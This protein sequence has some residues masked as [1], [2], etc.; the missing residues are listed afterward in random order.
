M[1]GMVIQI[2]GLVSYMV[3]LNDYTIQRHHQDQLR[4]FR[5]SVDTDVSLADVPLVE[6]L[7]E[8][9]SLTEIEGV[10]QPELEFPVPT[11]QSNTPSL[12]VDRTRHNVEIAGIPETT[13]QPSEPSAPELDV[14]LPTMTYHLH[15]HHQLQYHH[16]IIQDL[17]L[18][19]ERLILSEKKKNLPERYK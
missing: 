11:V 14:S 3:R 10:Y 15:R 19:Q 9:T 6:N 18:L 2:A 12:E 4:I 13:E 5:G 17:N 8:V 1:I 7:A 16:P